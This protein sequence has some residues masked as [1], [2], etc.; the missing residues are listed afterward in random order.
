M[1]DFFGQA[2]DVFMVINPGKTIGDKNIGQIFCQAHLKAAIVGAAIKASQKCGI[3]PYDPSVFN[4]ED[5]AAVET[6]IREYISELHALGLD[7]TGRD[8]SS[9]ND[10]P[11][12]HYMGK[13]AERSSTPLC[14]RIDE[15]DYV[16]TP[17]ETKHIIILKI[18]I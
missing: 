16:A 18:K 12:S 13:V 14:Q 5:F 7:N 9:D 10:L 15:H 17:K 2:C 6:T 1:L 11:L 8:E 3:E 4:D